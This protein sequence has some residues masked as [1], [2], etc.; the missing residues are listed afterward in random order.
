MNEMVQVDWTVSSVFFATNRILG[1]FVRLLGLGLFVRLL[2]FGV[3]RSYLWIARSHLGIIHSMTG[4]VSCCFGVD[5]M[6]MDF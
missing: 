5:I 3:V 6:C 1:F 4:G 2:G